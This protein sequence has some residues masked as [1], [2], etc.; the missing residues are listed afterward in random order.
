MNNQADLSFINFE[1]N[2]IMINLRKQLIIHK[3]LLNKQTNTIKR[4]WEK[5]AIINI[6]EKKMIEKLFKLIQKL[7]ARKKNHVESNVVDTNVFTSLL[8]ALK[9][10]NID[11]INLTFQN[12][13]IDTTLPVDEKKFPDIFIFSEIK[14]NKWNIF[15]YAFNVKF[16]SILMKFVIE[17]V[18]LRYASIKITK[19]I[20]KIV[21]HHLYVHESQIYI[22]L[23]DLINDLNV[24]YNERNFYAKNY[25]KL[26]VNT[27]KQF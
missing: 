18:K 14:S 10:L 3:N 24:I 1:N 8:F 26:I 25:V 2:E 22:R 5:R 15:K 9:N 27:F 16:Q 20:N 11:S 19:L 17:K 12:K 4:H 21:V 13:L 23:N 6:R 7:N